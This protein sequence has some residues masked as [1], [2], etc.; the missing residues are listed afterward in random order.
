[1]FTDKNVQKCGKRT[2]QENDDLGRPTA[3][4]KDRV[5]QINRRTVE[6]DAKIWLE[7]D[8]PTSWA[9][10]VNLQLYSNS[11]MKTPFRLCQ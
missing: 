5:A 6:I 10:T 3:Q 11:I 7:E 9:T 2:F 4:E 1:M 8:R